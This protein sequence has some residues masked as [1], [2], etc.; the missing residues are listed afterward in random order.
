MSARRDW[1]TIYSLNTDG[2]DFQTIHSFSGPDG[3]NPEGSL[4]AIG[5]TLYGTTSGPR[6]GQPLDNTGTVFSIGADGGDFQVLHTFTGA[7]GQSPYAGLT[8]IG[9]YSIRHDGRRRSHWGA[10]HRLFD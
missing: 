3:A 6:T 10:W 2:S 8:P 1:G 7:D 4:L 5:S 9:F